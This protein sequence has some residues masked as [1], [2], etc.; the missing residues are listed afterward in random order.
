MTKLKMEL[1][2]Y[3]SE[4]QWPMIRHPLVYAVP[5]FDTEEEAK[6]LNSMLATKQ[7]LVS[8]AM[9]E[10]RWSAYIF[11]H[12]RPWRVH[13]FL[14]IQDNLTDKQYWPLLREVWMDTESVYAHHMEWWELL[15]T[16]ERRCRHLFMNPAERSAFLKLPEE[17]EI[18]RGTAEEEKDS[19]YL[20][21]AWTLDKGRATWFAT[22][23]NRGGKS[24]LVTAT[25][26][27]A[28]CIGLLLSRNEDEIVIAHRRTNGII[29][30]DL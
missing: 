3:Y 8:E 30:E 5:Y 14:E 18:Y 19:N 24:V 16:S 26:K 12:E 1:S 9:G 4:A 2:E 27:K 23:F 13:A 15:T 11:L 6:R 20:G 21:F 28:D 22:R 7:K 25:V 17:I 29:W 10:G